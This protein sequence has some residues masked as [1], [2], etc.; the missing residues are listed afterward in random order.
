LALSQHL[1]FGNNSVLLVLLP[2]STR[3]FIS[4]FQLCVVF[5]AASH[6]LLARSDVKRQRDEV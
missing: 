4:V 6:E 3:L 2:T 1:L 5:L